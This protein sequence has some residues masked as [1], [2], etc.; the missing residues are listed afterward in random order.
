[1]PLVR[2][3]WMDTHGE[4]GWITPGECDPEPRLIVSVGWQLQAEKAGHHSIAQDW[5]AAAGRYNG[6]SHIVSS[7]VRSVEVIEP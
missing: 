3:T 4:H 2:I 7:C 1:M 6:V 5:D